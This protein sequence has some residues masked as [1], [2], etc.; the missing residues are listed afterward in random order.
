MNCIKFPSIC[1]PRIQ[2][3]ITK[4]DI[5]SVFQ[6]LN[7]GK[8]DRIDIINKKSSRGE[9]YKRVFIHFHYWNENDHAL[10][11]KE[12]LLAGKDIK[13]VYEFPWFWKISANKWDKDI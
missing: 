4:S 8:I 10:N 12:R 7:F 11:A 1:I 6:K 2:N 9:E 5:L 3:N 13:I